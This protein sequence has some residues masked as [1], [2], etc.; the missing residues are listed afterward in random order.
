MLLFANLRQN[1]ISSSL[2]S[3]T[4]LGSLTLGATEA[5]AIDFTDTYAPNNWTTDQTATGSVTQD[6]FTLT[7]TFDSGSQ[8]D[9]IDRMITI[10]PTG[11][12]QL[13][14]NWNFLSQETANI[15]SVGYVLNNAYTVLANSS[16]DFSDFDPVPQSGTG[17]VNV[18][19][20]DSFAFRIQAELESSSGGEFA[21]TNFNATP[22]PF[23]TDT[24]PLIGS[25]VLF[26][27]GIWAKSKLI[28]KK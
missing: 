25:T 1:W 23:E 4:L 12:G 27:L 20:G 19:A 16:G 13:T 11:V 9:Y 5:K 15:H 18:A 6:T 24:L 26:G 28:N 21:I 2:V 14:F 8:N 7:M 17:T 3:V 22:V 10:D